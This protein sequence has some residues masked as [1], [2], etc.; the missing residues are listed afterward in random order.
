MADMDFKA[1]SDRPPFPGYFKL[2]YVTSN[3]EQS[4]PGFFR[5]F[6]TEDF[7]RRTNVSMST[8]GG[9]TA[10][11]DMC[12][13]WAGALQ[14]DLVEATID[15]SGYFVAAHRQ[16]KLHST[17]RL[18]ETA[19]DVEAAIA[20][21]QALGHEVSPLVDNSAGRRFSIGVC[22]ILGHGIEGILLPADERARLQALPGLVNQPA[23][24]YAQPPFPG[25]YQF[26]YITNDFDRAKAILRDLHGTQEFMEMTPL[27]VQLNDN[28]PARM[29]CALSYV[30]AM[31]IEVMNPVDGAVQIYTDMMP[32]DGFILRHHHISRLFADYDTFEQ[33]GREF[34]AMGHPPIADNLPGRRDTSRFYYVDCREETGHYLESAIFDPDIRQWIDTIP[35][36]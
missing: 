34:A 22:S 11:V 19:A 17:G 6:G 10:T 8:P 28:K 18:F 20:H 4:A 36:R 9:G 16:P 3:L 32:E 26:T 2:I 12:S 30:G 31:E 21:F 33:R 29:N 27:E 7:E 1:G 25:F 24:D 35:R 13:A 14:L 15:P 23:F 5:A